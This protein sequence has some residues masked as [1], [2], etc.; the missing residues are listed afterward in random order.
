LPVNTALVEFVKFTARKEKIKTISR[1][2]QYAAY[3]MLP[4]GALQWTPLGNAAEIDDAIRAWRLTLD[5]KTN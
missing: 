4:D 5:P 3:I 2:E 1:N